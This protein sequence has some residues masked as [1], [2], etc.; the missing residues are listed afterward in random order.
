M[1]AAPLALILTL[2]SVLAAIAVLSGAVA[3]RGR[4]GTL[5]RDGRL[6]VHSPAASASDQ[7]FALA[8]RVAAPVVGGAAVVAAGTAVLLPLLDLGVGGTLLIAVLGLV[9]SVVLLLAAGSMG[10]RAARTVPIPARRPA[11][12]GACAG[13]GCGQGGCAVKLAAGPVADAG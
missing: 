3:V 9:G 8:N 6:G 2:A 4:A 7:A 11:G 10:E 13:C 5:H 12:G 1:S